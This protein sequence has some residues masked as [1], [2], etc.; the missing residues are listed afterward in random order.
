MKTLPW[1][2][3]LTIALA[4]LLGNSA[5]FADPIRVGVTNAS[6]DAALFIADKNGYF[7][8]EGLTVTFTAFDSAAKMVAPLG[9]GQLD[10]GGGAASG[11]LYNAV[12]RGIDLKIVA[13]KARNAPGYGFQSTLVRKELVEAGKFKSL[14]DLKGRKVAVVA[15]GSSDESVLNQALLS[16]GLKFDQVERVYLGFTQHLAAL[17]NGAVDASITTEPST[18]AVLK[19]GAAVRFTG[20]DAFYPNHQTAV[21]L[22]SG[23]FTRKQPEAAK[24]FMRAYV[25]AVRFYNDALKD[26]RLA[27]PTAEQVI[28]ILTEYAAIKDP[29]VFREMTPHGCNPDGAVNIDSLRKDWQFFRDQAVIGDK[30]TVDQVVDTSFA[31]AAVAGL[32]PYKPAR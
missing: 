18:T 27:G 14:A 7:K 8:D 17:Q 26:G 20:N 22:Y 6:S 28:A 10:V 25:R 23:E 4:V 31:A 2:G 29:Q 21:I 15:A 9:T 5:A 1:V 12:A 16:A 32:G 3:G 24:K 30:V 19:S 13:D 11:G